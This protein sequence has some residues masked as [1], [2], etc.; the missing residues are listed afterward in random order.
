MTLWNPANIPFSVVKIKDETLGTFVQE[1]TVAATAARTVKTFEVLDYDSLGANY[2][3]IYKSIEIQHNQSQDYS[4]ANEPFDGNVYIQYLYSNGNLPASALV[5]HNETDEFSSTG[6]RKVTYMLHSSTGII[7]DGVNLGSKLPLATCN[8][9]NNL[10]E[11]TMT[12]ERIYGVSIQ[13]SDRFIV[14]SFEKHTAAFGGLGSGAGYP[15]D[16]PRNLEDW[17]VNQ[18]GEP[19]WTRNKQ[20]VGLINIADGV[21]SEIGYLKQ[22]EYDIL[23]PNQYGVGIIRR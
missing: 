6:T 8:I 2:A 16:S 12:G 21:G 18:L 20:V 13:I 22:E 3:I 5:L 10:S 11:Y 19:I 15:Y 1:E 7:L 23:S 14:Y 4:R 9:S 17:N